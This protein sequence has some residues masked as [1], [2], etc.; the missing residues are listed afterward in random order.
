MSAPLVV[1]AD[2]LVLRAPHPC[3]AEAVVEAIEESFEALHRWMAW[4]TRVPDL[5]WERTHLV[6]AHERFLAG[7]SLDYFVFRRRDD[8][9]LGAC[10][11]PRIDLREGVYEIGYWIRT[12]EGGKGYVTEAVRR[13][14]ALAFDVLGARRVEIRT[15]DRNVRSWRVAERAGFA[16]DAIRQRDSTH[17]DGSPR[18]T[19]I[20]SRVTP[21]ETRSPEG[22]AT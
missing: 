3:H 16:L 13:C 22:G 21:C 2:R 9:F 18:D 11:F 19:R 6:E 14:A 1:E 4:A 17:P 5:A 8:R 15:S 7:A 20:Y 10:G 12:S